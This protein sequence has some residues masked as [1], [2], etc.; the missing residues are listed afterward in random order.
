[1]DEQAA[2]TSLWGHPAGA[3]AGPGELAF[4][5]AHRH[6]RIVPEHSVSATKCFHSHARFMLTLERLRM[7]VKASQYDGCKYAAGAL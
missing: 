7:G 4:L 1:V 3:G 5:N 2:D 6:Q